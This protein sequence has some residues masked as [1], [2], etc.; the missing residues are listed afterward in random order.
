[1]SQ[2]RKLA[3]ILVAGVLVQT[4]VA[5]VPGETYRLQPEDVLIIAVYRVPEI[6]AVLPVGPDGN[7]SAPF[8][9]TVKAGGKTIKELEADL[10]AAYVDR[11]KLNDPIVSVTIREYRRVKASVGGFVGRPGV[12]DMRPGDRLLDLVNAGG[13]TSTNGRADLSKAYLVKKN[14]QERIPID[15]RALLNGDSSQNYIV[16]DGDNLIVPEQNDNRVI[17]AGRVQRAGP[18]DYRENMTLTEVVEQAGQV[19][20]KSKLSKVQVFRPL[21]GRPGDFLAIEADLV[22][23]AG[24]KSAADNIIM[25]PGDLVFVPDSGNLDFEIIN[26]IANVIFIFD[27][28][29]INPLG[30]KN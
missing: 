1:M 4:A 10:T 2:L 8:L 19:P 18:V 23:F 30:T 6:N 25:R 14:S 12:Y 3:S 11:L 13:G 15:L 17:V 20:R 29:G 26:S 21:P 16:D 5:Q 9:G 7:I 28:F 24:G 22:A 27:R